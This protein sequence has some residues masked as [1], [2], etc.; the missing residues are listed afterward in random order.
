MIKTILLARINNYR[1]SDY[2]TNYRV[3]IL[4]SQKPSAIKFCFLPVLRTQYKF[5]VKQN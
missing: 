1:L 3:L 5:L 2:S 4:K